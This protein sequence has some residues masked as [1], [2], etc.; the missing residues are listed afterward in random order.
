MLLATL[1]VEALSAQPLPPGEG[2]E[3]VGTIASYMVDTFTGQTEDGLPRGWKP[4]V[5]R[6]V[7]RQTAYTLVQEDDNWF[8]RAVSSASASAVL[9]EVSVPLRGFPVLTWRWKV[10]GT[11]READARS[12]KGDD[13]AARIYVAFKYDPARANAWMRAKYGLAKRLY[14]EYPPHAALNYIWDN[15][16]PI[17]AELDNAYSDK[18]KMIVVESGDENAGRWMTERRDVLA[19]YR[20]AFGEDPPELHF[21]SLMT[22]TD[23]TRGSA[24]AYFDDIAF[25]AGASGPTA[26]R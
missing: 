24:T 8:V 13:Y 18:V 16:L 20:K 9:K 11:V 2:P 10:E 22:D 17:G 26:P 19:D 3:P 21:V 6:S 4:L 14:G 23:N 15:R 25:L 1:T 5:F 7:P 12:K